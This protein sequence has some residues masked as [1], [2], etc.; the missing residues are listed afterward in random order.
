MVQEIKRQDNLK[1]AQGKKREKEIGK[2]LESEGHEILGKEVTVK[3]PKTNRRV[4]FLIKDG[5]TGEIRAIE[6]KSGNAT[7]NPTQILKDNAMENA[8]GKIIGKNAKSEVLGQTHKIPTEV[9]H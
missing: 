2:K 3:T 6:V 4:D 7:R 8:G 9:R 1:K 5:K